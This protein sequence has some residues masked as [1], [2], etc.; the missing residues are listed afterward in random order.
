MGHP[1]VFCVRH[2]PLLVGH[3]RGGSVSIDERHR[4]ALHEAARESWG[5]DIA[6]TLMEMLPPGGFAEVATRSDI[7]ASS[8]AVKADLA[9]MRSDL[10]NLRSDLSAQGRELRSEI[11]AQGEELRKE[12]AAQGRELRAEMAAQGAELRSEMAAQGAELRSEM[13]AQ[14]ADLKRDIAAQG[15]DLR[16]EIALLG[17]RIDSNGQ[18]L[19]IDLAESQV[20]MLKWMVTTILAS[21]TVIVA[22]SALIR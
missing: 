18:Q 1:A 8:V 17:T 22:A 12:I 4:I 19:R 13:A 14:G 9:I 16:T 5:P 20:R 7:D 15:A 3:A 10:S 2:F 21:S 6:G 11:A